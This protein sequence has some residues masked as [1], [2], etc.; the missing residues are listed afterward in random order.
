MNE[1][2]YRR[3]LSAFDEKIALAELEATKAKERVDELKY[4]KAR[5]ILDV[6]VAM[7]KAAQELEQQ[8]QKEKAHAG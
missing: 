5:F 7:L 1:H 6:N 4:Q 2:E 8:Q 3:E